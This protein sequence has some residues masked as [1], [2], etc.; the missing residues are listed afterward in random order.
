MAASENAYATLTETSDSRRAMEA[1]ITRSRRKDTTGRIL[2]VLYRAATLRIAGKSIV[3][4]KYNAM[5]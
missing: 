3:S 5:K 2:F 4:K 1:K